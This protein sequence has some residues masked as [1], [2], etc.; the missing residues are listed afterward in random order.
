MGQKIGFPSCAICHALIEVPVSPC[1]LCGMFY[2]RSPYCSSI[3]ARICRPSS[4]KPP[5]DIIGNP[6]ELIMPN[7]K[8]LFH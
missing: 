2:H 4:K 8:D 3:H 6:H 5:A 7:S 1:S